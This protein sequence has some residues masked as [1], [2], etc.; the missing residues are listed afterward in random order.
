LGGEVSI[1]I[2]DFEHINQSNIMN[3]GVEPF[4]GY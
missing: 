2:P 1:I 3:T 4:I